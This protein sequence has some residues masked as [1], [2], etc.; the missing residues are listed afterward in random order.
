MNEKSKNLIANGITPD[1]YDGCMVECWNE[2]GYN[3]P[4]SDYG[5]SFF[6][7]IVGIRRTLFSR[8]YWMKNIIP[9]YPHALNELFKKIKYAVTPFYRIRYKF[10]QAFSDSNDGKLLDNGLDFGYVRSRDID[11]SYYM[12]SFSGYRYKL[13][14]ILFLDENENRQNVFISGIVGTKVEKRSEVIAT[15]WVYNRKSFLKEL[16]K[17][18]RLTPELNW[19]EFDENGELIM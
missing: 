17:V 3:F 9:G 6:G 16:D 18:I 12:V 15:G 13:M 4:F 5:R 2:I 1:M 11:K 14:R 7:K 10:I 19:F 8:L